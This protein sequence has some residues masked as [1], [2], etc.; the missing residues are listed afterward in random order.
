MRRAL[1]IL[2]T[3]L[4]A[5][6]PPFPAQAHCY[7]HWAYPTPQRACGATGV[8]TRAASAGRTA[9]EERHGVLMKSSPPPPLVAASSTFVDPALDAP[10]PPLVAASST[11][12][13]P[14]HASVSI[15][16]LVVEASAADDAAHY[17]AA[18]T[19]LK[20]LLTFVRR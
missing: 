14:V 12:V 10:V 1:L 9:H 18:M 15:P 2:A 4:V 6:L 20:L 3:L 11:F 5:A 7:T 19:Q 8:E 16:S 17:A 13:A